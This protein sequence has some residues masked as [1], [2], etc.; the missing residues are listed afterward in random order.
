MHS[1]RLGVL[2]ARADAEP[3]KTLMDIPGGTRLT[4]ACRRQG[5]RYAPP[6]HLTPSVRAQSMKRRRAAIDEDRNLYDT[7]VHLDLWYPRPPTKGGHRHG[8]FA[9]H[10]Y[11]DPP[12]GGA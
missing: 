8:K 1:R 4:T 11:P 5:L 12:H 2:E 3:L 9:I 6:L 7:R 10:R